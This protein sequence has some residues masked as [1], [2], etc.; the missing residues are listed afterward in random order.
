[1]SFCKGWRL[2]SQ[3]SIALFADFLLGIAT[4]RHHSIEC[5]T[6]G[7]EGAATAFTA[8]LCEYCHNNYSVHFLYKTNLFGNVIDRVGLTS[9]LKRLNFD[10]Q[11]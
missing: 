11:Q 2:P 4:A 7:A 1:M 5:Q 3:V 8:N 9:F 10:A 6:T